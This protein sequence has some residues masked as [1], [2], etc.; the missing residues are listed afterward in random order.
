MVTTERAQSPAHQDE[1]SDTIEQ[2]SP[3]V[4]VLESGH[5]LATIILMFDNTSYMTTVCLVS[6]AFHNALYQATI[7]IHFDPRSLLCV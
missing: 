3:Q 2:S 4:V 7:L 6:E 5:L 1:P